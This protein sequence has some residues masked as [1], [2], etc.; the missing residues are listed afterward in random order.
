MRYPTQ[1]KI[2]GT[3]SFRLGAAMWFGDY[4]GN[5]QNPG[6]SIIEIYCAPAG[7]VIVQADQ[8]GAEA[9]V[10]A[11]EC[12]PGNYRALFQNGIKP[13]TFLA[14]HIFGDTRT[15]W[16]A[17]DDEKTVDANTQ[18]WKGA[19]EPCAFWLSKSPAELKACANWKKLDSRIKSSDKE[20]AIGKRTAH[21]KSYRM[22]WRTYQLAN[23]KQ[24]DGTLVLNRRECIDFLAKFDVLF[25]EVIEGQT[26]T[27]YKVRSSRELRNKF[28]H[29]RR[30]EKILTDSYIREAISWVPQST[31]GCLTH[32]AFINVQNLIERDRR[33]QWDLVSN[34]HDSLAVECPV[35]DADD[36]AR[37][38]LSELRVPFAGRDGVE[39][40]MGAEAAVGRNW[41]KKTKYN[42]D[43]MLELK[44]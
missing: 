40:T 42:P 29:P 3:R 23:L 18:F 16:F 32:Q 38:L 11:Y 44:L 15:D 19:I 22:G 33:T 14:M 1:Y 30:F 35:S 13:H 39:Y 20:Y 41:G 37:I 9:L 34:K 21:G 17:G 24:S 43:G 8:A 31:V 36:V 6:K 5:L 10:V 4:G 2:T 25:P 26:E 28:G 12:K 7:R 27:E